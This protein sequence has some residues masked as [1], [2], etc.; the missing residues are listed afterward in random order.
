MPRLSL[1]ASILVYGVDSGDAIRH[2]AA[3]RIVRFAANRDC[4]LALQA[5]A[6]FYYVVTRKGKLDPVEA[7]TQLRKL[8]SVFPVVLPGAASLDLALDVAERYR[9]NFWDA[10]LL[11]VACEAGVTVLLTEDL[12]DGQ[13]YAGLRCVNPFRHGAATLSKLLDA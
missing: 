3:R 9:I 5:L 1:D 12:Q 11:A 13:E 2:R 4:V 10:M 7:R 8:R 6:E